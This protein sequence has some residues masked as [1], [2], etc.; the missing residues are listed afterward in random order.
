MLIASPV[1]EA[2]REIPNQQT[3]KNF[4][5][6]GCGRQTDNV[7]MVGWIEGVLW[8]NEEKRC[9]ANL[10]L[11]RALCFIK[12][13][14]ALNALLDRPWACIGFD[15]VLVPGDVIETGSGNIRL[16]RID[17]KPTRDGWRAFCINCHLQ[18]VV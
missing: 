16:Q 8:Y 13:R 1:F 3:A 12:T 11:L 6:T 2:V 4:N 17:G 7:E 5:V 10:Y 15:I 9:N 14:S 18:S